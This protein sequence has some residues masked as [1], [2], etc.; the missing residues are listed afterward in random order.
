MARPRMKTEMDRTAEAAAAA[1]GARRGRMAPISPYRGG[2]AA[3]PI[4]TD[5]SKPSTMTPE[6]QAM[7]DSFWDEHSRWTA[8]DEFGNTIVT[9]YRIP[10]EIMGTTEARALADM[11]KQDQERAIEEARQKAIQQSLRKLNYGMRT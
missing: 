6:Q 2:A 11:E 5:A 4:P 9:P 10:G 1:E 7:V 3:R 8:K